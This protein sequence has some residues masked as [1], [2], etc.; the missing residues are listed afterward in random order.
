[1]LTKKELKQWQKS[2][3]IE[4]AIWIA[5]SI[6]EWESEGR[7]YRHKPGVTK[8]TEKNCERTWIRWRGRG[9]KKDSGEWLPTI[10]HNDWG[11]VEK[12]LL[13][14]EGLFVQ[15]AYQCRMQMGDRYST[16]L[17]DYLE[18]TLEQRAEALVIAAHIVYPT[19]NAEAVS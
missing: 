18:C 4:K 12:K 10:N 19:K 6:M 2:S 11:D 14:D 7:V 16:T 1:M 15:F 5:E 17:R 3:D 13:E 8:V 9:R